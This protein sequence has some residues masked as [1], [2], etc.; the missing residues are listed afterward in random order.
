MCHQHLYFC[1]VCFQPRCAVQIVSTPASPALAR[2]VVPAAYSAQTQSISNYQIIK[3]IGCAPTQRGPPRPTLR[4]A[5][6]ARHCAFL[7]LGAIHLGPLPPREGWGWRHTSLVVML[8][9]ALS[10]LAASILSRCPWLCGFDC[11]S[12]DLTRASF[13]KVFLNPATGAGLL[14][15]IPPALRPDTTACALPSCR[16]S[17]RT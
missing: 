17:Q 16:C 2:H 11:V 14:T 5:R 13:M 9:R 1:A 6:L 3:V 7:P 12:M 4:V 15:G 10:S 8:P